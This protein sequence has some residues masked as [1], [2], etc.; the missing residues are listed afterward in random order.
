MKTIARPTEPLDDLA[1]VAKTLGHPHRL[2][3]LEAI[4]Q[5]ESSVERLAELSGLSITNASQHLLQLKRAGFVQSRRDGKHVMYRIGSG[6]VANVV[7]ALHDYVAHQRTEM[8]RVIADSVHHPEHLDGVSIEELIDRLKDGALLL[9][10]RSAEDYATGHIPGAINIPTEELERHLGEL[11]R[12]QNILA[13]C[14]GRYCVLSIQAVALLRAKGFSAD[15][16]SDGFPGW[17]A[18]GLRV[19]AAAQA[20]HTRRL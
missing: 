2:A 3:L 11:P 7:A 4:F 19:E 8:R 13:Y 16:V 9:D 14:G 12:N 20:Q 1:D 15:R 18:A 10:V 17:W 6:P 5:R